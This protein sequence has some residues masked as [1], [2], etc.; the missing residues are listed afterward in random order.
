MN[1][2]FNL[3]IKTINQEYH[4]IDNQSGKSKEYVKSKQFCK[5][6]LSI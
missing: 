2:F 3:I 4:D 1:N 6:T 5:S